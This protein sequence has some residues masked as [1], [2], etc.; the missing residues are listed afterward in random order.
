MPK[1]VWIGQ[2]MKSTIQ[3]D[4]DVE[5]FGEEGSEAIERALGPEDDDLSLKV[6]ETCEVGDDE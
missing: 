1:K 2:E 4:T 6:E 5:F 3:S